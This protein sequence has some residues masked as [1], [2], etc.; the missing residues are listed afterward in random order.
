MIEVVQH[1]SLCCIRVVC[2]QRIDDPPVIAQRSLAH[3]AKTARPFPT[4]LA[5][6]PD[7]VHELR[8]KEIVRGGTYRV[9][10][11]DI[12]LAEP[13]EIVDGVRQ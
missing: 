2:A 6:R 13:I 11:G 5:E 1:G 9:V 4:H 7:D 10:Q 12:Q 3:L 8:E